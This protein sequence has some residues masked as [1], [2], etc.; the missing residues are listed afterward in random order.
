MEEFISTE[1]S[2]ELINE[3][4]K[5]TFF[6][7][8]KQGAVNPELIEKAEGVYFYTATGKKFLDFASQLVN[9]NIGHGN[10]RVTKAIVKQMEKLAFVCPALFTTK[11]RGEVGRKIA[12]VTPG[13][14]TKTFFTLGGAEAVENAMK[15]ARWY[16]GKQK[17]L[18]QYRSYHGATHGAIAAG[19][20]PRNQAVYQN[21][22][23]NIVHFEGPFPYRCPWGGKT[24]EESK[25]LALQH[26]ERIIQFEGPNTIAA[27]MLEGESGTSGCVNFPKGYWKGVKALTE[28]YNILTIADEVMSGFGRAGK[29]FG[30]ENHDVVPDML[31]FAKG[32]TAGYLPLGG[33][34]VSDKVSAYFDNN[35]LTTGLTHYAHPVCLAA[36]NEVL[37]IYKDDKIIEN[38]REMGKY[39]ESRVEA[40]AEKHPS[41]G[42]FRN[43]GLLGCIELVKNRDNKD[44]MAPWNATPPEMEIMSKVSAKI[45]ECGV[46]GM[47]RWNWIFVAPPLIVTKGQIDEG[48]DAISKG[49]AIADEYCY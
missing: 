37:D 48:L 49:I 39:V 24:E 29:W 12:E 7:W 30:I 8:S 19:G 40:L 27:I 4:K 33:V 16:T 36:A 31:V 45:K 1:E 47:V 13:N 43:R 26:L 5:Y 18:T 44:P 42:I 15:I 17:I 21:L 14:L 28:K 32:I 11:V 34:V 20:D 23:P 38:A 22:M 10:Q 2:A 3:S 46:Y 6:P 25:D 35:P 41:I 9:M